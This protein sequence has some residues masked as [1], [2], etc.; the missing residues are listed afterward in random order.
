M[1]AW[2]NGV[3]VCA[4]IAEAVVGGRSLRGGGGRRL[5]V[6]DSVLVYE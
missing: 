6:C 1:V 5:C 3:D 2:T 4:V